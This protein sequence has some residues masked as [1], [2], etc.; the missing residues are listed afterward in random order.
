MQKVVIFQ[1]KALA[2]I[3]WHCPVK[4]PISQQSIEMGTTE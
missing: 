2:W 1:I 4:N 3:F